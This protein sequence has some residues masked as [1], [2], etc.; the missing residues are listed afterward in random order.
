MGVTNGQEI[1]VG[2]DAS[3]SSLTEN[4]TLQLDS[5]TNLY[6]VVAFPK[7]LTAELR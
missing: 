1:I 6:M 5:W 7:A 4:I 3:D 2:M